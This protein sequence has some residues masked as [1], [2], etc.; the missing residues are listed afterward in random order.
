M[1]EADGIAKIAVI[2]RRAVNFD[3]AMII[4]IDILD[5]NPAI[6]RDAYSWQNLGI[7][8][9]IVSADVMDEATLGGDGE[10]IRGAIE[11]FG[12]EG[13]LHQLAAI[14]HRQLTGYIIEHSHSLFLFLSMALSISHGV[15]D[16]YIQ[17][18]GCISQG[19]NPEL[20]LADSHSAF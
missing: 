5:G 20:A 11:R 9:G 2:A 13:V 17:F 12:L 4:H 18:F 14:R 19:N 15:L 6:L 3:V 1:R 7:F 16:D 10:I 8:I